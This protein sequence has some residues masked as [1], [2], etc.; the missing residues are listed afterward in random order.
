MSTTPKTP[1]WLLNTVDEKQK[2]AMRAVVA[3]HQEGDVSL[4]R[5]R[6]NFLTSETVVTLALREDIPI[7]FRRFFVASAVHHVA[8]DPGEDFQDEFDAL[9]R[10]ADPAIRRASILGLVEAGAFRLILI[11]YVND[12][13][14]R[15]RA[16]ARSTLAA[17]A[18]TLGMDPKVFGMDPNAPITQRLEVADLNLKELLDSV[19]HGDRLLDID[20]PW[21]L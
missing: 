11:L 7:E 12:P 9:T 21:R 6:L 5:K 4:L 20:D 17:T 16:E 1:E 13:N 10:H 3:F 8:I 18:K 14:I 15:V 19:A 2:D